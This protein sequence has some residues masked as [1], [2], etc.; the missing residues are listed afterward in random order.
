ML[1]TKLFE[2]LRQLLSP[3]RSNACETRRGRSSPRT[4]WP[5]R[6]STWCR[7]CPICWEGS[8]TG[9]RWWTSSVANC[10]QV[11]I[12]PLN[13]KNL[14]ILWRPQ[15]VFPNMSPYTGGPRY[16]RSFYMRFRI[17]AIE[18]WSFFWNLS[19]NLW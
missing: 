14:L 6:Q 18:K 12:Q 7:K 2:H 11:D 4:A 10:L 15:H 3:T 16:M 8:C 19:S 5:R 9:W 13:V 17:Y 1:R